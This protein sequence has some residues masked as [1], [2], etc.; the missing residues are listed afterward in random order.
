MIKIR[1]DVDYPY[2][3]R[4][5]SF[6]FT[7]LS[8][9]P[10]KNYDKNAKI[11][12]KMVNQSQKEVRAY[13]FFTPYT[14]PDKELLSLLHPERHE[15]ALHVATK[16]Y[17]EWENLEKAT[18]RKV[19]YYTVHGTARLL[20]RLMWKRKLW[21]ARA[22]I[23]AGFPLKSFYDFPT[24]GLD[25]LCHTKPTEQAVKAALESIAKGEV[26]HVHP[27]WLF[28][29]GTFNHRGP[30]Y[31]TLK[32]LLEVDGEL[33]GLAV[34][35]KG[36]L[37]VA[38][39]QEQYEYIK[40]APISS[41]FFGKIVDRDADMFTF[42]ERKW[43]SPL[44][45]PSSSWLKAEDNIAL[46][47]IIPYEAWLAKVGKKTR[48]MVRKAQ[49]SGVQTEVVEPTEQLAEGIWKIYNETPIRQGRAFSH[50]G[51]PLEH[52]KALVRSAT[53][54]TFIAESLEGEVV[55]FV[56]LV[57]G[58]QLTVMAQILSL[59]KHWDKALNNALVAKAVEVCAEK[60][61]P[62]LM[63]GRM[64]NHPSL[65]MFKENNG[66][67]KY[68]LTRYYVPLTKKGRWAAKLGLHKE[69]KDA[70]P[71]AL[72]GPLIPVFNWVSRTK[73]KIKRR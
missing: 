64:G 25:L 56:Q 62:W 23:P 63:Y 13:W 55:G 52:V 9:P 41:G 54:S 67:S 5:Q 43:C 61:V 73:I 11:I 4:M 49:K 26:L 47:Q 66:F 70:L 1:L 37:K 31:E 21:E 35:K 33:E 28:E 42:V 2:P 30:Y 36:F 45:K 20:A 6:L 57:H 72:K 58:D 65:D 16:P 10:S 68:N 17:V 8:L 14:I 32:T 71:Q 69:A 50:Y 22:P 12:A 48:N 18:G 46:L 29:R 38:K 60:N 7:A 19:K 59:Q 53:N 40:D 34:Q 39:Y 44:N 51:I 27:E 24:L 3:S 15:V